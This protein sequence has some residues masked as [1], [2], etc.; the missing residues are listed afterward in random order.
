MVQPVPLV[1]NCKFSPS[2]VDSASAATKEYAETAGAPGGGVINIDEKV[3][4]FAPAD[5]VY[6][7]GRPGIP[8]N[9]VLPTAAPVQEGAVIELNAVAPVGVTR[10]LNDSVDPSDNENEKF[11]PAPDRAV[12]SL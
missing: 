11:C 6:N 4:D 12:V 2:L 1:T 9:A 5:A 3:I 7:T 8:K 10:R